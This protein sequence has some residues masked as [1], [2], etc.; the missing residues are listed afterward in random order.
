MT[1]RTYSAALILALCCSGW[2][3][4]LGAAPAT[5]GLAILVRAYRESPTPARQSAIATYLA[6]HPKEAALGNFALGVAAYEQKNYAAAI[7]G[8]KPLQ[9]QLAPIG[10]YVAY[11]LAAARVEANDL[12][13]TAVL[14]SA[15]RRN[16]PRCARIRSI[17]VDT[18]GRWFGDASAWMISA[19]P[20]MP[21]AT[22]MKPMPSNNSGTP[23]VNRA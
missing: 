19:R 13:G 16:S 21:I 7:A 2:V 12:E 18:S 11:Y 22:G 20:N 3:D 8:L 10:D 4:T 23:H 9:A 15:A 6:G 1:I 14:L 5:G 17:D